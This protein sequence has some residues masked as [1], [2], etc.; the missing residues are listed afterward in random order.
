MRD[1]S[2]STFCF[3]K[4]W[5]ST[6]TEINKMSDYI[7]EEVNYNKQS[8]DFIFMSLDDYQKKFQLMNLITDKLDTWI[9]NVD[10]KFG[11][12]KWLSKDFYGSW[13]KGISSGGIEKCLIKS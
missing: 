2:G 7:K 13:I 4:E 12:T 11:K 9:E 10:E 6:I 1:P 8:K 3:N 5:N